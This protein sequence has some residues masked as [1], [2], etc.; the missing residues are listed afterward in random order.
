[1]FIG[2]RAFVS[3]G[4]RCPLTLLFTGAR[5]PSCR[6]AAVTLFLS[7]A[8]GRFAFSFLSSFLSPSLLSC[9]LRSS[10]RRCRLHRRGIFESVVPLRFDALFPFALFAFGLLALFPICLPRCWYCA[11][12]VPTLASCMC[13]FPFSFGFSLS[14]PLDLLFIWVVCL[15]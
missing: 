14:L 3:L 6:W 1:M 2:A 10:H 15:D 12:T 13:R 7:L 5:V 9:A 4:C 11:P 8:A